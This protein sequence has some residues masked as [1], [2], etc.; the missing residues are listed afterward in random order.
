MRDSPVFEDVACDFHAICKAFLVEDAADV[1]LDGP[2]ADLKLRRDVFVTQ[3]VRHGKR[4]ALLRISQRFVLN[5]GFFRSVRA[6]EP[7]DMRMSS[8]HSIENSIYDGDQFI[9]LKRL[10]QVRVDAGSETLDTIRCLVLRGEKHDRD[11]CCSW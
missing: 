10:C 5:G 8:F 2:H 4:D 7:G 11:E 1:V 9:G 6:Y 3:A